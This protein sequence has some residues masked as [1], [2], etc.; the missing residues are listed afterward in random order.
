MLPPAGAPPAMRKGMR[1]P[2]SRSLSSLLWKDEPDTQA[3]VNRSAETGIVVVRPLSVR[4]DAHEIPL[5]GPMSFFVPLFGEPDMVSA[6]GRWGGLWKQIPS[7][8]KRLLKTARPAPGRAASRRRP[9][10]SDKKWRRE[11]SPHGPYYLR[12]TTPKTAERRR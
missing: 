5:A 7:L 11:M 6:A 8:H 4:G 2:A 3:A 10:V 12:S 1:S 9:G